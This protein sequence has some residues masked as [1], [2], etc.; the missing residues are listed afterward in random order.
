LRKN[1][2]ERP[3]FCEVHSRRKPKHQKDIEA[4]AAAQIAALFF[5]FALALAPLTDFLSDFFGSGRLGHS[6]GSSSPPHGRIAFTSA[7][8]N[9]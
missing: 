1:A 2:R 8:E 5:L 3:F 7:F 9:P 6:A 4:A